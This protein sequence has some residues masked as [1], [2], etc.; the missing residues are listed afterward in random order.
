MGSLGFRWGVEFQLGPRWTG[1]Q[2][3]VHTCKAM[4]G[5]VPRSARA[6]LGLSLGGGHQ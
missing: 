6:D 2:V 4:Q 1:L 5:P 3:P